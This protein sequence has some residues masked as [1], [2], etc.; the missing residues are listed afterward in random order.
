M[1]A[2]I[3]ADPD[4]YKVYAGLYPAH[5]PAPE[6]HKPEKPV[7]PASLDDAERRRLRAERFGIPLVP[8]AP[9]DPTKLAAR[10]ARFG[11][12]VDAEEEEKRRRRAERFAMKPSAA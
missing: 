1:I 4:V 7:P 11:T 3:Q 2:K 8:P 12:S 6:P 5:Q 10:A 9:N